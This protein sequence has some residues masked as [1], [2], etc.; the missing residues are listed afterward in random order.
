VIQKLESILQLPSSIMFK[1]AKASIVRISIPIDFYSGSI[2]VEV[3]GIIIG[4]KVAGLE[5][6][7]PSS[8]TS[9]DH[10]VVPNAADLAQSFLDARPT[11]EYRELEDA[12][13]AETQD[14]AASVTFTDDGTDDEAPLGTGQ[15]LTLPGFLTGFLQ[16]I[17]DRTQV[18][19]KGVTFNLDIDVPVDPSSPNS[20]PVSLQLALDGV[21]VEGVTTRVETTEGENDLFSEPK[22]G[23]RLVSLH[24]LRAYLM[25]EASLFSTLSQ[26]PI[27]SPSLASSPALTRNPPS[28]ETSAL[29]PSIHSSF[30]QSVHQ[31]APDFSMQQSLASLPSQRSSSD[32][33]EGEDEEELR[34]SEIAL[35]IPYNFSE[36]DEEPQDEEGPATPRASVYH[37][38][39]DSPG[40]PPSVYHDSDDALDES[41]FHSTVLPAQGLAQST[42]FEPDVP[43]WGSIYQDSRSEPA[44]RRPSTS[45]PP[46]RDGAESPPPASSSPTWQEAATDQLSRSDSVEDLTQS[47]YYTHEEAESMYMSAFSSASA[48]PPRSPSPSGSHDSEPTQIP[49]VMMASVIQSETPSETT[50]EVPAE[51]PLQP[52][53]P[54]ISPQSVMPGAWGDESEVSDTPA[55]APPSPEPASSPEPSVGQDSASDQVAPGSPKEP[56][57]VTVETNVGAS[58]QDAEAENEDVATPRGPTRFVK[59]LMTLKRVSVY[60]PSSQQLVN[61]ESGDP[62]QLSQSLGRSV[63]PQAPGAFSVHENAKASQAPQENVKPAQPSRGD[64][65]IEVNIS[66]I[67]IN[68]DGSLAFLLATIV[69]KLADILKPGGPATPGNDEAEIG[70]T[71]EAETPSPDIKVVLHEISINFVNQLKGVAD[72][73]SRNMDPTAFAFD[74]DVLFNARLRNLVISSATKVASKSASKSHSAKTVTNVTTVQL[75]TFRFGFETEDIISFIK[76]QP[77]MSASIRDDFLSPGWDVGVKITSSG[78]K[79]TTDV[80][81]LRLSIHLDLQ[82]LD[83]A[84]SWFGGLSSFL[85]MSTSTPSNPAKSA[86]LIS[87][88]QPK[89]RRQSVRFEASPES[90]KS[91]ASDN[92]IHVRMEGIRTKLQGRECSI[93]AEINTIR[94]VSRDGNVAAAGRLLRIAGPNLRTSRAEPAIFAEL[95]VV[96]FEFA[97]KPKEEDLEKLLG[98]ILPSKTRFDKDNDEIMIDTLLR[99]R[100]KGSVLRLNVD[101]FDLRVKNLAQLEALPGLG[102]E[103]AKL[104]AVAKYLPEDDRPG[105]LTLAQIAH[106]HADVTGPDNIGRFATDIEMLSLGHVPVPSLVAASVRAIN[107][108]RNAVEELLSTCRGSDSAAEPS[109][110]IMMRMI[111]DEIDPVVKLK[112]SNLAV[113]YRVPF[114]MDV[115]GLKEDATP[116]DFEAELAASVANLG[117]HAQTALRRPSLSTEETPEPGNPMTLDMGFQDCLV[118]LNPLNLKSK[119]V[120]ALTDARVEVVLPKEV[121][122]KVDINIRKASVLLIDDV[123]LAV[124]GRVAP[125]TSSSSKRRSSSTTATRQV[126]EFCSRGYAN[127]CSVSN[128]TIVLN[129]LPGIDGAN[130]IEVDVKE[131]SLVLETC[132]DSMQTL[133][134]LGNALTPPTPP[135]KGEKYRTDVMPVEDLLSS[136]SLEAFGNNQGE[137]DFDQDFAGARELGASGSE[138]SG[139]GFG[140]SNSSSLRIES[141]YYGDDK[142]ELFDAM[143]SSGMSQGSTSMQDTAEGVLLTGMRSSSHIS[144]SDDELVIHEGFYETEET[145]LHDTAKLWS[146]KESRQEKA[147]IDL[148]KRS[149]VKISVR[150]VD[151]VWRLYD[152]YDWEHTRDV[153][154][155]AVHEVEQ[156]AMQRQARQED[157]VD[158]YEEEVEDGPVGDYLFKSI[159]IAISPEKDP[160]D[161]VRAINDDVNDAATE[162]ESIAPTVYTVN[163]GRAARPA[164]SKSKRL[165]L[166]RSK[167]PKVSFEFRGVDADVIMYPPDYEGE[168]RSAISVRVR[169]L[170]VLD[171]IPTSTWNKFATYDRDAGARE[172]GTSM[173]DLEV[174]NVRP[175][176]HVVATELVL[177]VAILPLRLHVDQDAVE[178]IVRFFEFK[179]DKVPVHASDS[180]IP[181]IQR[182]EILDVAVKLDFKPKRVDYTGLRSGRTTELMNFVILEETK[183][184]MRHIIL[185]GILGFDR[186][187]EMLNDLWSTDIKKNQLSTVLAGLAPVRSLVNITSGFR[188]LIEVPLKEYKK[189]GRVMRSISKGATV[190]V[191]NT[192]TELVKFGAKLAVGTQYALQGAEEMLTNQSYEEPDPEEKRQISLYADQ[193]TS[194]MQ[195]LRGGYR[196]LARDISVARDAII[197]VPAEVMQSATPGG[198][199]KAVLGR[200]PTIVFRPAM[201]VSKALGQTLMGVTNTIDPQQQRRIDDVSHPAFLGHEIHANVTCCRNTRS[202][203]TE[204]RGD[205]YILGLAFGCFAAEA[206]KGQQSLIS[207]TM[208]AN[209]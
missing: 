3:D 142:E 33:E 188:D 95:D 83:E 93:A 39:D 23:K 205:L 115:L 55:Y 133:I 161:L 124:D 113:E 34:D 2:I 146:W 189:D 8:K 112:L 195:G 92:T 131:K 172:M 43:A 203:M 148:V 137:Y 31:S 185:H 40:R 135:S 108:K 59:E 50:T 150:D 29:E 162:T 192:G 71:K 84:F 191:K 114:I 12:I 104:S 190:F 82:R 14:L 87:Q 180:D 85:N 163:S 177:R 149:P 69:G 70:E 61:P 156:R 102:E 155:K 11:S 118:G 208:D 49:E 121:E 72:T 183:M 62:D 90:E 141:Q 158:F 182:L 202:T 200:A 57:H 91:A 44:L 16:G 136:I 105:L 100:R 97:Q 164:Q 138:S 86:G 175:T 165:R 132:A 154:T 47:H 196:S 107:V 125:S 7:Q 122:T 103:L 32:E 48:Q 206:C 127:I 25:S 94:A 41:M 178:F 116:Q 98:L 194:V 58:T 67:T 152:G 174:F 110:A 145:T 193:P 9:E 170:E 176:K 78:G 1:K 106:T 166:H 75:E 168:T 38:F 68:F 46:E 143:K 54:T 144:D 37:G 119:M 17:V 88:E 15:A 198:A 76:V 10:N 81:T 63:F 181:F 56:S 179:D 134:T 130:K 6:K 20:E 199:A 201:G 187:G 19:I 167:N 160:H 126:L 79:S 157:R 109:P 35:G 66:P 207:F 147:P 60:L 89:P 13:A 5:S 80:E 26:S 28:R 18:K 184:V 65:D 74:H 27:T 140:G 64:S 24:N 30:H 171:H 120:L 169:D 45:I 42:A 117:D 53:S 159:Y 173:V 153:I 129:V 123:S 204:K 52:P 73:P 4:L 128:A 96:R 186:M 21:D 22:E 209:F 77:P 36:E 101:K 51:T 111:G 197:A 151:F 99:Q 139:V